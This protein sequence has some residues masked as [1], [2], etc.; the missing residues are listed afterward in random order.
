MAS[1]SIYCTARE[2]AEHDAPLLRRGVDTGIGRPPPDNVR[3]ARRHQS[4][5]RLRLH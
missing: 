4:A 1:R 2:I 3:H 5:K